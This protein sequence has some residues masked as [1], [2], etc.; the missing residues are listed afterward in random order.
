M[1][2]RRATRFVNRKILRRLGLQLVKPAVMH[3]P[4]DLVG[5]LPWSER[6]WIMSQLYQELTDVPGA[7]VECGVYYG[8][9]LLLQL[10]LTRF[11]SP[12]RQIWGFDSFAGHSP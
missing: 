8:S 11:A 7:I 1:L 5:V 12:R 4:A 3:G 6:L 2:I 9:G 10:H